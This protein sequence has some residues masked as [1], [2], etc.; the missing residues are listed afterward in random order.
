MGR[1]NKNY[2]SK[3]DLNAVAIVTLPSISQGRFVSMGTVC[4]AARQYP[5]SE[6]PLVGLS[7]FSLQINAFSQGKK[8]D[9]EESNDRWRL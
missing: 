7:Y 9:E 4:P 5:H 8:A 1:K 2:E 3:T 6:S